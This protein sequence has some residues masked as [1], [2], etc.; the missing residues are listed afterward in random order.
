[1][2][3]NAKKADMNKKKNTREAS[4]VKSG[5]KTK[6]AKGDNKK[7]NVAKG[8]VKKSG[9]ASKRKQ[10]KQ[11]DHEVEVDHNLDKSSASRMDRSSRK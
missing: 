2:T 10:I 4:V 3:M 1:M 8:Q 7:M 6:I 11:D 9:V 5:L